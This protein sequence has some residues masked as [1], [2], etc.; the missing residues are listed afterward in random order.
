VLRRFLANET[1]L[2]T[3]AHSDETGFS[4]DF[5]GLPKRVTVKMG[6]RILD[7]SSRGKT[8]AAKDMTPDCS[9][10]GV[11]RVTIR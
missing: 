10:N 7:S 4:R 1:M 2:A 9:G 6:G 11:P 5:G 3:F 8:Q